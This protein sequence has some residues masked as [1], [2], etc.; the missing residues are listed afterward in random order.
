[1]K[2]IGISL[3][4][5]LAVLVLLIGSLVLY[6]WT[7]DIPVEQL[8]A[9]WAPPPSQFIALEGMQVHVRDEGPRDDPQPVLLLHGY[10]DSLYTWDGWV[11]QL[12]G[13]HRVIRLDLPGFG[14]T[15]PAADG[16]YRVARYTRLLGKLLDQLGVQ[17]VSVAGNS[18]GGLLAWHLALAEPQRVQRLVLVDA[19]GYP[20]EPA[21]MPLTL[22]VLTAPALQPLWRK[23][24]SR[25]LAEYSVRAVVGDP[26]QPRPDIVERL[27]TLGLREGNRQ[28]R[29][30][31]A[32][33]ALSDFDD[34]P[35][36]AELRVPT[37]IIW[38]GRDRL[39]PPEH[40]L[41]FKRDIPGSRLAMFSDLG[42]VPQEE[43]PVRSVAVLQNYLDG[44]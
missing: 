27:Y 34:Y 29:D 42:H 11:E 41:R 20:L 1:M 9:R 30:D 38:G 23:V 26:G 19:A 28:A 18:M 40:A 4:V 16:D 7:P 12:K 25:Q 44:N 14:L 33:Q 2:L 17:H 21:K 3:A 13:R 31:V 39:V 8:K 15:G 35:R 5:L 6:T 22:R 36:I 24:R 32:A 43:D 10:S 37:L